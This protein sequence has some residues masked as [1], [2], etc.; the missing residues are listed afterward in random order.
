[1]DRNKYQQGEIHPASAYSGQI[2]IADALVH[3]TCA[4]LSTGTS[5][6]VC[7]K[8]SYHLPSTITCTYLTPLNDSPAGGWSPNFFPGTQKA[9][10]G[11]A[12]FLLHLS[13][14][15]P[16][17]CSQQHWMTLLQPAFF[18]MSFTSESHLW[19]PTVE[20]ELLFTV[21]GSP[22]TPVY[23]RVG[24]PSFCSH[25][26]LRRVLNHGPYQASS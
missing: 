17:L 18:H 9:P 19:P 13:A 14:P 5:D 1:M 8:L 22:S 7:P 16:A 6:S 21:Y 12:S 20:Q 15:I 2:G 25:S 26:V 24:N 23:F 11:V 4:W 10:L 3:C